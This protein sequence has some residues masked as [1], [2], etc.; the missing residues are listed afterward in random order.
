MICQRLYPFWLHALT[1]APARA[2]HAKPKLM[3]VLYVAQ[4][5]TLLVRSCQKG[6]IAAARGCGCG[7]LGGG[8]A[9]ISLALPLPLPLP[10]P[11]LFA[12]TSFDLRGDLI[13]IDNGRARDGRV[14]RSSRAG[15][16]HPRPAG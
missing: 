13:G 6:A 8:F 15:A 4:H 3:D 1:S 2:W 11:V 10:L 12:C 9:R 16:V 5:Q 14:A 7:G